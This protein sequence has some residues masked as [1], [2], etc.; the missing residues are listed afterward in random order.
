MATLS[1]QGN[2]GEA[3]PTPHAYKRD[4]K[5]PAP[6]S[7]L[8]VLTAAAPAGAGQIT[9]VD[10]DRLRWVNSREHS[11]VNSVSVKGKQLPE[12]RRD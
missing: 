12:P 11:R 2:L 10:S 1:A 9:P 8:T 3:R 6:F 5:D 7:A 4:G